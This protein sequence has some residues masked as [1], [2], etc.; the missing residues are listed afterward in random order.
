MTIQAGSLVFDAS[1]A[2]R[3]QEV[4]LQSLFESAR[5]GCTTAFARLYE[6]THR[7][8]FGVVLRIVHHRGDAEDVL[9][10]VYVKVWFRSAQFD[11]ARGGVWNWLVGIAHCTA[12]DALRHRARRPH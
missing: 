3:Q 9:Q 8:I 12:I 6:L 11:G 7:R 2:R 10:D 5:G 1:L 4:D